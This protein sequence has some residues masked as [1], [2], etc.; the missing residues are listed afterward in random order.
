MGRVT[1]KESHSTHQVAIPK[2]EL[3]TK[4]TGPV[5]TVFNV[6]GEV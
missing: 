2:I 6:S 3:V 4:V 1:W 5:L